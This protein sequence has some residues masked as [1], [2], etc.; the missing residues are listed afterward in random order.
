MCSFVPGPPDGVKRPPNWTPRR[1]VRGPV[2]TPLDAV[3]A[4]TRGRKDI[5]IGVCSRASCETK[6]VEALVEALKEKREIDPRQLAL[7]NTL[8]E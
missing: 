6:P 1:T 2:L 5:L 7:V 4:A 3:D 8:A